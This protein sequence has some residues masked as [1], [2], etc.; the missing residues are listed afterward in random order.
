VPVVQTWVESAMPWVVI[1]GIRAVAWKDFDY[2]SL[3]REWA[4]TAPLV[5]LR[6]ARTSPPPSSNELEK[7]RRV[8]KRFTAE[9]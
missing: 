9:Y 8:R 2:A 3:A 5:W 1:P 4:A 6:G 7:R